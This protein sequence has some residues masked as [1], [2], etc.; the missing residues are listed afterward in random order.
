MLN[1]LFIVV[2]LPCKITSMWDGWSKCQGRIPVLTLPKPW[3][4]LTIQA[5]K[6]L[7]IFKLSLNAAVHLKTSTL[8]Y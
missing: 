7:N 8:K 5:V 1:L 2:L 3:C 4:T 6:L